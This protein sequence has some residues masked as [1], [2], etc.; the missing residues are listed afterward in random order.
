[1]AEEGEESEERE[2]Q[3][4]IKEAREELEYMKLESEPI[5]RLEEHQTTKKK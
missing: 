1:M 5:L 4:L 3:Q 2:Y